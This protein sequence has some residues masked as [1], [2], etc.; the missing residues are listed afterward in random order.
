MSVKQRLHYNACIST[1]KILKNMFS[2]QLR[3]GLE[4][5]G[6]DSEKQTRQT[7]DIAIQFPRIRSAQKSTRFTKE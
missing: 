1:F 7:E 3:N 4:I 5:I 2:D 6:N